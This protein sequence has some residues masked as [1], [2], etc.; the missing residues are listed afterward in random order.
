[1]GE[2]GCLG[3]WGDHVHILKGSFWLLG[4]EETVEADVPVFLWIEVGH[5]CDLADVVDF[6]WQGFYRCLKFT[7]HGGFLGCCEIFFEFE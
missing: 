7:C 2:W 5:D 3:C 6:T 4:G 1:M